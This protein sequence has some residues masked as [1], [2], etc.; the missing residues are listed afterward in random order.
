MFLTIVLLISCSDRSYIETRSEVFYIT[1]ELTKALNQM[2]SGTDELADYVST[3]HE[4]K[5]EY[6]LD[7][8]NIYSFDGGKY[9]LFEDTVLYKPVD[10]GGCAVLITGAVKISPSLLKT[11]R[12]YENS[13]EKI[14]KFVESSDFITSSWIF[15]KYSICFTYP[16]FD[17]VSTLPKELDIT[18]LPFYET[19][20]FENNKEKKPLWT[21]VDEPFLGMSGEGWILNRSSPIYIDSDNELDFITTSVMQLSV[22]NELLINNSDNLI[23]LLSKNLSLIG[24]SKRARDLLKLQVVDDDYYLE[25]KYTHGYLT[26]KYKL[27]HIE[28][29]SSIRELARLVKSGNESFLIEID[30]VEY[31]VSIGK[32]YDPVLYVIGLS[33]KGK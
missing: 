1:D 6:E 3:L 14:K 29:R 23:I 4:T 18:Q 2:I 12:L 15:D 13:E 25:Q 31:K 24:S 30:E 17:V 32:V 16:Y 10:D 11:I 8:E 7:L 9:A 20:N 27:D 28:Q 19:A 26:D 21:P 5:D 22:V 33:E